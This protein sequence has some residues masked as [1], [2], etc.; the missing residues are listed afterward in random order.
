MATGLKKGDEGRHLMTFHPMGGQT[1]ATWF[2]D[3]AWLDFN[4]QQNGHGANTDV[5]NRIAREYSKTPIKP[6]LDGEPLYEDHPIGFDRNKNGTSNDVE[7][8]KF[9]Y[10]DVFAGACGHTYGNHSI[11]QMHDERHGGG[12]NGPISFW[13][14]AI[15]RPGGAQM[16]HLRRLIESRPFLSRIPDQSLLASNAGEGADHIQATRDTHGKFAFVYSASGRPFTVDLSKLSGKM[17]NAFWFDPRNGEAKLF[18]QFARGGQRE[19]MPPT[20]GA[21][22]DWVLV[23]DDA[24]RK[25]A[26]P[27]STVG[28]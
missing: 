9:A 14:Q 5:W 26:A 3:D 18:E 1:S 13:H 11:W 25:F 6:V 28:K 10:W 2:H 16:G 8:R 22:N 20:S 21:G 17:L 23:L 27:G 12:V 15:H 24:A 7:I 4:M 19:F